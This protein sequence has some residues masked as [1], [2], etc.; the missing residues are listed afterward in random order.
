MRVSLRLALAGLVAAAAFASPLAHAVVSERIVAVVGDRAIL[1]SDLRQR[2]RPFLLQI[3]AR[4]PPGAQQAAAESQVFRDLL[5][6]MVDEE[7]EGQ[8][9]EKANIRVSSEEIENAFRNI[10]AAEQMTVDELFR[11]ARASSGLTE[12]EYRDEIRRQILEGKMLQLRVKGRVRITEQ[13]VRSAFDRLV[14]EERRRRDYHPAWIVL[15][16]LPG[17]SA[18]AVEERRALAVALAERARGGEDFAAL[19]RQFSD[20]TATREEGGDLGVRAPQGTQAAVTGQR[21][22]MAPELEAALMAIEPGGVTGPMRAGDA[23]VVMKLLSRQPSRFT[24]LEAARPEV[25]Q[26]LQAE[27]MTKAKQKWLDDLKRGT[28]VEVRL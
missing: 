17:S 12:Q 19:A 8:A 16:V 25:F 3:Q 5:Q 4:V 18:E 20:D 13:D 9:A 14:R 27:I 28:H 24:T 11:T 22:V 6:K 23:F 15:R 2:A 26:R 1:L 21:E 7:L 10:A